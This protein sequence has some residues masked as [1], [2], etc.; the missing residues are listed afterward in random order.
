MRE[1]Y[2]IYN[3]DKASLSLSFILIVHVY[4]WLWSEYVL[5]KNLFPDF[6]D[7]QVLDHLTD[8]YKAFIASIALLIAGRFF[9]KHLSETVNQWCLYLSVTFI[10]ATFCYTGYFVGILGMST[11]VVLMSASIIGMVLT[12]IR[13]VMIQA[14]AA[15]FC[16][17]CLAV[18]SAKGIIPYAPLVRGAP[19]SGEQVPLFWT[20][21]I[22]SHLLPF[23]ILF[24]LAAA[25]LIKKWQAYRDEILLLATT[26]PLTQLCNRRLLF[27]EFEREIARFQRAA[28]SAPVSCIMIDLDHFKTINDEHGHQM[29]DQV[30][31]EVATVLAANMREYDTLGRYGGEEFLAVLPGTDADNA[32]IIA[33]RCQQEIAAIAIRKNWPFTITASFGISTSDSPKSTLVEVMIRQADIAMQQAKRLGK[34]RVAVAINEQA[35]LNSA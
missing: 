11:G 13:F 31:I 20:I 18:L 9:V 16:I 7:F 6:F 30:L 24:F 21:S 1:F 10:S 3:T 27:A 26:D 34:N 2:K 33:E 12:S 8:V 28:L 15:L 25:Y 4:Y 32:L 5:A 29:G 14:G 17:M 19:W 23:I 22:L 35:Q